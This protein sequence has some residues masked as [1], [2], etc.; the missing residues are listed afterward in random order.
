[1]FLEEAG[2]SSALPSDTSATLRALRPLWPGH[3]QLAFI[4]QDQQGL[5][6]P[7]P[8][9]LDLY[10]CSCEAGETC[11]SGAR[12]AF[13]KGSSAT[14]GGLGVGMLLLGLLTLLGEYKLS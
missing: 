14:V 9:L 13:L 1:M 6:C 2:D 8:Q 12:G 3:Y 4:I 10:V 11:G 5:A 7:E